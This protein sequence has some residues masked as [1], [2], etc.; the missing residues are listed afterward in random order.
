M[1][2]TSGRKRKPH[3]QFHCSCHATTCYMI[4]QRRHTC[5][6]NTYRKLARHNSLTFLDAFSL[7]L[8]YPLLSLVSVPLRSAATGTPFRARPLRS[9]AVLSSPAPFLARRNHVRTWLATL[10]QPNPFPQIEELASDLLCRDVVEEKHA[11]ETCLP[12]SYMPI[13]LSIHHT[14]HAIIK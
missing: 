6:L 2:P 1:R 7:Y 9:Q 4:P 13:H 10:L 12:Y 5:C 3:A 14:T 11:S 8:R